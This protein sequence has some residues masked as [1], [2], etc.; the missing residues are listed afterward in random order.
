MH[1]AV[2]YAAFIWMIGLL[3]VCVL[4]V[5]RSRSGLTRILAVDTLGLV[6]IAAL[7]LLAAWRDESYF[8]DAAVLLALLSFISTLAAVRYHAV[9]RLF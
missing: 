4:V 7:V 8:L 5:I 2:F 3:V 6:S 9:R 1:Q